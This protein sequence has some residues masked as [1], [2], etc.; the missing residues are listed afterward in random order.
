MWR[1][2]LKIFTVNTE[3]GRCFLGWTQS[4]RCALLSSTK[5]PAIFVFFLPFCQPSFRVAQ[6]TLCIFQGIKLLSSPRTLQGPLTRNPFPHTW[7]LSLTS[8][9]LK[10]LIQRLLWRRDSH[11]NKLAAWVVLCF[12]ALAK[13]F[14][15]RG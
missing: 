13:A 12:L 15:A 2:Q 7:P 5:I 4:S 11:A 14:L 6:S 8:V 1:T 10:S 3:K 9:C